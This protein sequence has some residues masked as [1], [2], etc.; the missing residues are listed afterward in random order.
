MTDSTPATLDLSDVR[1]LDMVRERLNLALR[2]ADTLT[3]LRAYV[4]ALSADLED[5]IACE[6]CPQTERATAP[7]WT[8]EQA[9][10]TPRESPEGRE[11]GCAPAG[12]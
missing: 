11:Y 8:D 1:R 4:C 3:E 12:R 2:A 6:Q 5:T 10:S 7:N 9:P